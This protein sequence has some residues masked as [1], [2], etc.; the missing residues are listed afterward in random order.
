[1][2]VHQTERTADQLLAPLQQALNKGVPGMSLS[3][4]TPPPL[5]GATSVLPISFVIKAPTGSYNQ[6]D[7]V[8]S[9]IEA[10]AMTSGK[11]TFLQKDLKI[12]QPQYRLIVDRDLAGSLGISMQQIAA[13]L[14]PLLS[15]AW[16]NRFTMQG[17][18]YEVIPQVPDAGRAD[19]DKLSRYHVRAADG[20][21]ISLATLVHFTTQTI[22]QA[23]PQ[24]NGVNSAT[25]IGI[26]GPGVALGE[27]LAALQT[28][29]LENSP[30][31]YTIDYAGNSRQFMQQ[32]NTFLFA[33]VLAV[34]LIYLLMSAQFNS[35]RDA[36]IVMLTIP[37]SVAGA[38]IFMS[39]GF[40]TMNIYTQIALITLLGLITKQGILV[41]Q[42]ANQMQL[43]Q[44]LN[45]LAAVQKAAS[46]RLRPI[47]MTTLAMVIGMIPLIA[48][49]GA[50]APP[51]HQLGLVIA[52]GLGVGGL[53]SLYIVPVMYLYIARDH[54]KHA[55]RDAATEA[56]LAGIEKKG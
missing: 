5:P 31:G 52:T 53:F 29:T 1:M 17:Y 12:D 16:I 23:L 26:P 3:S 8:S 36:L 7:E 48:A 20:T 49:T 14:Q 6:L 41:V 25:L 21:L 40:A 39:L 2:R 54:S 27:A 30:K 19:L 11:F 34:I 51:R 56:L 42:F 44:G 45:K 50:G 43:E 46:V 33:I 47:L 24:F 10:K 15:G 13:T 35:F 18:S 9:V 38:L 37:M 28:I 55:T 4:G 22:P 32:G